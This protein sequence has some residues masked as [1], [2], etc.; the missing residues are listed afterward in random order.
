MEP[1]FDMAERKLGLWPS[2]RL[3]DIVC[4][5]LSDG[6][7]IVGVVRQRNGKKALVGVKSAKYADQVFQIAYGHEVE[8]IGSMAMLRNMQKMLPVIREEHAK[9]P[10]LGEEMVKC[11]RQAATQAPLHHKTDN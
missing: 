6:T 7:G 11:Y 2:V 5:R 3:G 1:S 9:D 10:K 4:A 8:V